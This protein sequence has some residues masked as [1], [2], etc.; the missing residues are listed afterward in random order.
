MP[1]PG[2]GKPHERI[3]EL[4]HEILGSVQEKVE[5]VLD[6]NANNNKQ[7]KYKDR[8]VASSAELVACARS[9]GAM[10]SPITLEV[11]LISLEV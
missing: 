5:D 3:E 2:T 7:Y 9:C 10:G 8:H 6:L 1:A 11:V 4:L